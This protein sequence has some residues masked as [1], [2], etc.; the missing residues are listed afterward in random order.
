MEHNW[1]PHTNSFLRDDSWL[2]VSRRIQL[3]L[4]VAKR[5]VN[6]TTQVSVAHHPKLFLTHR[7]RL[8]LLETQAP[9][10]LKLDRHAAPK[11]QIGTD[12]PEHGRDNLR[13][14]R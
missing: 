9:T 8:L 5:G 11:V 13:H 7:N 3:K 10:V 1:D 6:R 14:Q 12:H 2:W 4:H